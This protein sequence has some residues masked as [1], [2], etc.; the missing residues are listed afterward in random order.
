MISWVR[1]NFRLNIPRIESLAF[2]FQSEDSFRINLSRFLPIQ[3]FPLTKRS[4][5]SKLESS[6]WHPDILQKC[7]F[8]TVVLSWT[9]LVQKSLI[10]RHYSLCICDC[11]CYRCVLLCSCVFLHQCVCVFLVVTVSLYVY[12]VALFLCQHLASSCRDLIFINSRNGIEWKWTSFLNF[13]SGLKVSTTRL[14]EYALKNNLLV[15]YRRVSYF[16]PASSFWSTMLLPVV[17]Y[18]CNQMFRPLET[19]AP[20][21]G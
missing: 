9:L 11:V 6:L 10:F 3:K 18:L 13:F 20:G 4:S 2:Y 15:L 12:P 19:C 5:L 17:Q 14:D 21:E 16:P 7:W 1:L 8:K